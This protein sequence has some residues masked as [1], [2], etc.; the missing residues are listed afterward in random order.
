VNSSAQT[1]QGEQVRIL[2]DTILKF[3]AEPESGF[4]YPYFIRLPKGMVVNAKQFLLVETNNSGVND[5]LS[6]HEKE[7]YLEVIKNSLGA[8]LCNKLKTPFLVPVFPRPK[9]EENLYTHALDRDAVLIKKGEMKRLDEQLIAMTK[10]AKAQL[11]KMNIFLND[12]L[13]LNGFSASGTFANRFT[14]LH[15]DIVAAV[16]CGGINGIPILPVKKIE[17]CKLIYPLG[18][19]DFEKLFSDT[20]HLSAYKKVPQY[21]YMGAKDTNDAVLFDDA[22]GKTERE[23][24]YKCIGKTMQPDRWMKCQESYKN[25][26]INAT[27]KTY[28]NIGHETDK[29]VYTDV[30]SFFMDIMQAHK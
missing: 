30:S 2:K 22:Y 10:H 12:K 8:S 13:L 1:T 15:P 24:V 25:E 6:F 14:L 18:L 27:F 4:N 26:G 11:Q 7:T 17:S 3:N 20:V 21:I 19:Y 28:L 16:A 5:S 9:K 23:I 29:E